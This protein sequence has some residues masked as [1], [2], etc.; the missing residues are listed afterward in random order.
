MS[1]SPDGRFF[2]DG[3][4]WRVVSPDG[5]FY[6][7]GDEWRPVPPE[8]RRG[9]PG[10][11]PSSGAPWG[12]P[13]P[14]PDLW[15][16]GPLSPEP[17]R[18]AGFWI[19]LAAY[20]LDALVVDLVIFLVALAVALVAGPRQAPSPGVVEA[21]AL[22]VGIAYFVVLWSTRG[23]T[24]GMQS[25]GLR[26]VDAETGQR[27]TVGQA[28]LRLVGYWVSGFVLGLGFLWIAF[29]RRKQGWHDKIA[30]TYVLRR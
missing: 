15:Q 20:L 1:L 4:A 13:P 17:V 5:A 2:W 7:V 21:V 8:A 22:L 14:S 25:L 23:A 29:D 10:G 19:R 11:E 26:L 28:L 18:F 24:V 27:P 12:S 6:L 9:A 30:S 3:T 16:P